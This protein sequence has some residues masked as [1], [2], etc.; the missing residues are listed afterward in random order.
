MAVYVDGNEV[1][2]IVAAT[3]EGYF[4]T[5]DADIS[6]KDVA[7]DKIAYGRTGKIVGSAEIVE[8]LDNLLVVGYPG[9]NYPATAFISE[10][11]DLFAS[12]EHTGI[13]YYDKSIND[14]LNVYKHTGDYG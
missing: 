9:D 5:S 3:P 1:G 13:W 2:T 7:K 4:D 6:E 11:G 10:N 8:H 14:W 12:N